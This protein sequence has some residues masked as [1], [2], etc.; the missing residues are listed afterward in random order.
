MIKVT[1]RT[2]QQTKINGKSK[3]DQ[4]FTLMQV[5]KTFQNRRGYTDTIQEREKKKVGVSIL[6]KEPQNKFS[7]VKDKTN[8]MSLIS[9]GAHHNLAHL[10]KLYQ[11][12]ITIFPPRQVC[13]FCTSAGLHGRSLWKSRQ[14][15]QFRPSVLCLQT[16]RPWI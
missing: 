11:D 5:P 10:N 6:I 14:R 13:G 15:S 16:Q 4:S 12:I 3:M 7:K 2:D 8:V 1:S 9:T